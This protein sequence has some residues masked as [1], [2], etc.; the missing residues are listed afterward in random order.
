MQP[1]INSDFS[2]EGLQTGK[3]G[4]VCTLDLETQTYTSFKRKANP[5]DRRNYVVM[6]GWKHGEGKCEGV[7]FDD[8]RKAIYPHSFLPDLTTTSLVIGFNIKFDMLYFWKHP[9]W[10]EFLQAGG[11]VWDC[12]YVEYLLGGQS[13]NVQMC[14]LNDTALEYGGTGKLDVIKELWAQGVQTSDIPKDTLSAYLLGSEEDCVEGDIDSTYRVYKGQQ[15]R[16]DK[17]NNPEAFRAMVRNRMDGLLATT[18]ME[19]N[20]LFIDDELAEPL[21]QEQI[22]LIDKSLKEL[23]SY[24]PELPPELEWNW[25]SPVHKSCVIFGGAVKYEKWTAH[26]DENG[27][28]IYPKIIEQ[29]PLIQDI[30]VNPKFKDMKEVGGLWYMKCT[31]SQPGAIKGAS[32]EYWLPQDKYKSGKKQ[33]EG[34]FRNV[35]VDNLEK[36]KGKKVIYAFDLPRIVEP[37]PEWKV[38]N[39]DADGNELYSTG[40]KVLSIVV[41]M[42]L[43]FC[44]ALSQYISSMKDLGTYFWTEDK[45]GKRTG[46]LTLV[47]EGSIIHHKLNHTQTVTSRL[48]SSDPNM[49]NITRKAKSKVKQIFRSRFGEEG[50]LIS[51]DY[52]QLEI[53]V[54]AVLTGDENLIKDIVD[55]IDFHCRRLSMMLG[56]TYEEV[57][58]RYLAKHAET[59]EI[60]VKAKNFSFA[61]AFGAGVKAICD[62]TGLDIDTVKTLIMNEEILYP[63]VKWFDDWLKGYLND[64]MSYEGGC[65]V[66]VGDRVMKG[67]AASWQ[68]PFGTIFKFQQH[69]A[70]EYM[71][72]DG[73]MLTFSPTE[74]KNYPVQ[75]TGGEMVQ[76]ALGRT[77]RWWINLPEEERKELLM[78]NTVHDCAIWDG[79]LRMLRRHHRTIK[80]L[81]EGIHVYYK[82]SFGVD[83]PVHFRIDA[84]IGHDLYDMV[85]PNE[86]L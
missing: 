26:L 39:T 29:W 85:E 63:G 14:N 49:Q 72:R 67:K 68:S 73:V 5:F 75:G 60:R 41:D 8:Q 56:E 6:A 17:L 86:F 82:E 36:P 4:V 51:F 74:R 13:K 71:Q 7:Y 10:I 80:T 23:N 33:G 15:E 77:F 37:R 11:E 34:K 78:I 24:L 27:G 62:Q 64:N 19:W 45:N 83:L 2:V 65:K 84:E 25:G 70:P 52:K 69:A 32:G 38:S 16:I 48:S 18:E 59:V 31:A 66:V 76:T 57:L 43:P 44:K 55:E 12:Q 50:A 61:R 21:R 1:Q 53:L 22:E 47:Q 35:K 40:D 54:Q 79:T 3:D 81:M 42:D 9:R 58:A 46:M 20:G 28:N 30:P